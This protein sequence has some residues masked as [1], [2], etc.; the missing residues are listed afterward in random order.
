MSASRQ[1]KLRQEQA[2]S[3]PTTKRRAVTEEEKAAKRLKIWSAVFYVIIGLMVI[4][5]AVA[6]IANTGVLERTLTAVTIGNHKLT[7]AELNYYYLDTVNNT[8]SSNS[9]MSYMVTSGT[10]LD[11]QEYLGEGFD[12]WADYFLD[13]AITTARNTYAIYDE[14]VAKGYTLSEEEQS[15]VDTALSNMSAYAS[16]Y[17][18]SSASAMLR[19]NYGRGCN[20]SSYREYL[21]V[22]QLASSYANKYMNDLDYTQEEIDAYG[23]EDPTAYNSYSY[24]YYLLSTSDYYEE[25]VETPNDEQ[26]AA[27]L[28]AVESAAKELAESS[29]G[30]EAKF[31]AAVEELEEAKKAAQEEAS[32]DTTEPTEAEEETDSTLHENVLKSNLV[33]VLSDWMVEDGRQAGDT[34][35]V[36]AGNDAGFYVAMYL[37]SRDNSDVETVNVRHILISTSDNVTAEDAKKQ[38]EDLKTQFEEDPTEEHFA[39]MAESHSSDT[40]SNTNGG[41]Y[42]NVAPGQMVDAFNDWIFDSSRKAGDVG[43]VETTYGCHLIYFVGPGEYSFRDSLIVNAK[44]SADYNTWYTGLT[45]AITPSQGLGVRFVNKG[46]TL[47]SNSSQSTSN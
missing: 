35:Y 18:Y 44:T 11:E 2:A 30:D 27:A 21:E 1:K 20:E 39:E 15:Q 14:A 22:Q 31:K 42:E 46:I 8:M 34:T 3:A 38:I 41:L 24:R 25:G 28:T 5:V 47:Q 26:K 13:T 23:A 40:G 6:A 29:K 7:A 12:T 10:P 32:T 19:A 33:T 36:A 43:V 17:G 16:I 45:E 4:G 9:M 37:D